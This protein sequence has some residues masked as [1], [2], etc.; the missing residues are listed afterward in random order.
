MVFFVST[1]ETVLMAKSV[2][3]GMRESSDQKQGLAL[4][5]PFGFSFPH[6]GA[7]GG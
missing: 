2:C 7:S 6:L 1:T 5:C 4:V 3:E